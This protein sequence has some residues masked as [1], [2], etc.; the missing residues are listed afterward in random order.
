MSTLTY[1]SVG[2]LARAG[3]VVTSGRRAFEVDGHAGRA[4]AGLQP[5]RGGVGALGRGDARPRRREGAG[6]VVF[7]RLYLS[8]HVRG[9]LFARWSST[10]C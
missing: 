7:M 6:P 3:H 10:W 8:G 9:G 4:V 1:F 5:G 2:V